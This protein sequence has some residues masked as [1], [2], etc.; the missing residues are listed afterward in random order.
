MLIS[1]NLWAVQLTYHSVTVLKRPF[2]SLFLE[3]GT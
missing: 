1:L 3:P 2:R